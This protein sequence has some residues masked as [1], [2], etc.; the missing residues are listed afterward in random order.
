MISCIKN[1]DFCN[2][3][4]HCIYPFTWNKNIFIQSNHACICIH[5]VALGCE[6]GTKR[7]SCPN[8]GSSRPIYIYTSFALIKKISHLHLKRQ[9]IHFLKH[10]W[11]WQRIFGNSSSALHHIPGCKRESPRKDFLNGLFVSQTTIAAK[12]AGKNGWVSACN[13]K[14]D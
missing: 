14:A 7:L 12:T 10:T 5:G 8:H 1:C 6:C 4:H 9:N 2:K 11:L 3:R 13:L